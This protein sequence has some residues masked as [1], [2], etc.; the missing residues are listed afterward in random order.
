MC[1]FRTAGTVI[2]FQ[3]PPHPKLRVT[4]EG[5]AGRRGQRAGDLYS[6]GQCSLATQK[7]LPKGG[8]SEL[9]QVRI[10][11]YGEVDRVLLCTSEGHSL[12][13]V[14]QRKHFTRCFF[15]PHLILACSPID[16]LFQPSDRFFWGGGLVFVLIPPVLF[17][18]HFQMS[19]VKIF[20]SDANPQ[21][22][23]IPGQIPYR[24]FPFFLS[25]F[26]FFPSFFFLFLPSFL[27]VPLYT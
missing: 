19:V 9:Y 5:S 8:H 17:H 1:H 2:I 24:P 14:F 11:A 13:P 10:S 18:S 23:G 27:F 4:G 3:S 25:F 15:V 16:P 12:A 22:P 6:Q 7:K 20:S 26:P 21:P